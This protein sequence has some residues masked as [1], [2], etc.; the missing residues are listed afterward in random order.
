MHTQP[1][2]CA[3]VSLDLRFSEITMPMYMDIHEVNGATAA[4]VAKP[5]IAD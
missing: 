3:P 2:A 1:G 4:D 5:H